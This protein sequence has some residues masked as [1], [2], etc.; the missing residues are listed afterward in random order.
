MLT[1]HTVGLFMGNSRS[2]VDGVVVRFVP[3]PRAASYLTSRDRI[4]IGRWLDHARR[5][6]YD[7]MVIHEREPGDFPEMG[8]IL[9]LHRIGEAWSRWVFARQG[10]VVSVWCSKTGVDLGE[11]PTLAAAFEAVMPAPAGMLSLAEATAHSN[12]VTDFVPSLVRAAGA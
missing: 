8:N 12:V 2:E 7:R 4:E 10:A 3:K 6:G 9:C 5:S 11:F 1:N